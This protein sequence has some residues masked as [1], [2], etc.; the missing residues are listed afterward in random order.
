MRR[1]IGLA[2]LA[3]SFTLMACTAQE[4]RWYTEV[5]TEEEQ[6]LV[7]P[8]IPGIIAQRQAALER[9]EAEKA[10][11]QRHDSVRLHPFLTCVRRHESDRGPYP[12]TNGYQAQNPSS[13]ASGAYQFLDSTWRNVSGRAGHPGYSRAKHAPPHVQDAVALWL[14]NNGGRSAWAGS[15]C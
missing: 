6:A 2:T 15:G 7:D 14:Y 10:A 11:A 5:A 4:V 1:L 12:H 13:S 3:L 8:H 9:A